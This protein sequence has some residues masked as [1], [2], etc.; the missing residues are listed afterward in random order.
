MLSMLYIT[1]IISLKYVDPFMFTI[2]FEQFVVPLKTM[3]RIEYF[4]V[5]R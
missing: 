3:G 2:F 5:F 1:Y 4:K